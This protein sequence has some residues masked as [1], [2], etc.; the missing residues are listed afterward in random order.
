M[1]RSWSLDSRPPPLRVQPVPAESAAQVSRVDGV[2]AVLGVDVDDPLADVEPVVVALV[3]LVLVERLTV[4]ERPLAFAAF[5]LGP[6]CDWHGEGFLQ[7]RGRACHE[8]L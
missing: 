8:N 5:A 6:S 2:E 4:A 7:V 3:F 1:T